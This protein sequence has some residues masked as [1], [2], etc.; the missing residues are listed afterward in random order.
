[1]GTEIAVET[2]SEDSAF[3]AAVAQFGMLLRDSQY[4]GSASYEGVVQ[5]LSA[6]PSVKEDPYK[7]EL[8]ELVRTQLQR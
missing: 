1:M 2:P 3:A 4:K 5:Q 7:A 6:L 8:L